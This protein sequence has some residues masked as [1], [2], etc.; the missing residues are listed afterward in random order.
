MTDIPGRL[1]CHNKSNP[2][3]N[4]NPLDQLCWGTHT[5]N[6]GRG[7]FHKL[8]IEGPKYNW[9]YI[10]TQKH[11]KADGISSTYSTHNG[12]F[13]FKSNQTKQ[14]KPLEHGPAQTQSYQIQ[15]TLLTRNKLLCLNL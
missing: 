15:Q 11:A 3:C 6:G 8:H 1:Q 7:K 5:S 4:Q 2:I 12:S 14:S 10:E 13:L 9:E